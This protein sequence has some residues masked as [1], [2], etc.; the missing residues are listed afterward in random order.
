LREHKAIRDAARWQKTFPDQV[1]SYKVHIK[2]AKGGDRP[3]PKDARIVCF[4]GQPR[5]WQLNA[6]WVK[7]GFDADADTQGAV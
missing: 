2:T 1:I 3:L 6:P 4:H 5:P 7:G